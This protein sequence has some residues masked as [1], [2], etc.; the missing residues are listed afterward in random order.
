MKGYRDCPTLTP[1][2]RDVSPAQRIRVHVHCN[3]TPLLMLGC[4]LQTVAKL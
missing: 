2:V 3:T 1:E 4:V